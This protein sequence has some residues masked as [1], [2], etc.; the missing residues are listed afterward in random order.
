VI[1]NLANP[2]HRELT[3]VC[4]EDNPLVAEALRLKLSRHREFRWTGWADN[5]DALLEK[6]KGA[7]PSIIILD[8]DMPGKDPLEA[9]EELQDICPTSRVVVFTGHVRVELI[10]R[11]IDAGVWG[12]V[13]KSDG[14]D[15]LIEAMC[16][17]AEGEF[18]FSPEVRATYEE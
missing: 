5:A 9:A 10:D 18:A 16:K 11:A 2:M 13:A 12:Y 8:L 1:D 4:V 15:A 14:D 17:V 7:C 6:C 3:V